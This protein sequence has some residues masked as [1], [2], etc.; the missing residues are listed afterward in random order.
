MLNLKWSALALLAL[1]AAAVVA[2]SDEYAADPGTSTQAPVG[3][4]LKVDIQTTFP[5]SDIFG[6]K[7]VNGRP[8]KALIEITNHEDGPIN[9][10]F[11]GGMLMTTQPLPED[12]PASAAILRNLTAVSYDI[13]V[14]AGAKHTM[15]FN[16][17]LDMMPQDIGLQLLAVISN[18]AGQIFQVP[19]HNGVA[20]IVE[21]PTNI[22]DPQIIFLYI[23]L[24]AVFGG[25]LY[26]V[27][28]TW[29]EALFPQAKRAKTTKKIHRKAEIVEPVN[30]DTQ[31]AMV[32]G[33]DG[34]DYDE[35][36][37][38]DLHKSRPVA[39]RVKSG[40][41]SK[42]KTIRVAQE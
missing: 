15:P 11:V 18:E 31:A 20:S 42:G 8:T 7:L 40:A 41:S 27:Y 33:T 25:T 39:K 4:D 12:A 13:S 19:A 26:F 10:A 37:I 30:P 24:T 28:K 22:F 32:T 9:V 21:A 1:R 23:F 35:S 29:I 16:F 5:E 2:Q 3:A 6:V 34:K 38:P 17:V 14:P 36:W